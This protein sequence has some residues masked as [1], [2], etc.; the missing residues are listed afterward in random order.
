M[1]FYI[2]NCEKMKYKAEYSPS[3]LLCPTTLEWYPLKSAIPLLDQVKFTPFEPILASQ[4]LKNH[5][6]IGFNLNQCLMY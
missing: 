2:H 1:G 3:E 4:I 5:G 6:Q